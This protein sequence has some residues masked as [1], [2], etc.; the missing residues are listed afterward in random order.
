MKTRKLSRILLSILYGSLVIGLI[1][2]TATTIVTYEEPPYFGFMKE[3]F[4]LFTPIFSVVGYLTGLIICLP[5]FIILNRFNYLKTS[6]VIFVGV[7]ISFLY[8]YYLFG[9]E[10]GFGAPLTWDRILILT[11]A[12]VSGITL[13]WYTY[14][15]SNKASQPT[16]K[17]GA[18]EL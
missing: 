6:T 16:P 11:I 5:V 18:A 13:G 7:L 14:T 3:N 9:S 4:L 2:G 17:S 1:I 8:A 12:W 10:H 15:R